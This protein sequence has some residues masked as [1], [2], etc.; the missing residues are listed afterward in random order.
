MTTG[1]VLVIATPKIPVRVAGL[2]ETPSP[3]TIVPAPTALDDVWM[4]VPLLIVKPPE[5][6]LPPEESVSEPEPFFTIAPA[7]VIAPEKVCDELS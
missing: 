7:S 6:L 2:A 5:K 3:S 4:I 1:L